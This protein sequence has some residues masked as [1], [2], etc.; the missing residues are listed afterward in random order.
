MDE[1]DFAEMGIGADRSLRERA[2]Y[3]TGFG[4]ERDI[5]AMRAA[6]GSYVS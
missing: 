2:E 3:S 6:V 1:E 4:S 5:F